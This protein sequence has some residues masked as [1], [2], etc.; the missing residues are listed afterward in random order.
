MLRKWK[1]SSYIQARIRTNPKSNR[2]VLGYYFAKFNSNLSITF[3]DILLAYT[4]NRQQTD[5]VR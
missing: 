5:K 4:N 3:R 1:N 2:L